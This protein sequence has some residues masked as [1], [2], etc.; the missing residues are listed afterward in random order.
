MEVKRK[1]GKKL[2]PNARKTILA[3]PK[4][5]IQRIVIPKIAIRRIVNTRPQVKTRNAQRHP[6][7]R[8]INKC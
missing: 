2:K 4:I 5:V 8:A 6:N 3:I 1:T 7:A